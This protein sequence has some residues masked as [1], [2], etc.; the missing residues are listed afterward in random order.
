MRVAVRECV[1]QEPL[2]QN[3]R[4]AAILAKDSPAKLIAYKPTACQQW[5]LAQEHQAQKEPI[6]SG[7]ESILFN[8]PCIPQRA[9]SESS[10]WEAFVTEAVATTL[11]IRARSSDPH[12]KDGERVALQNA[13]DVAC[14]GVGWSTQTLIGEWFGTARKML[15]RPRDVHLQFV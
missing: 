4:E 9:D 13:L 5:V 1:E 10:P 15:L 11:F 12:I 2:W 7:C 3:V 8:C 14:T 6:N